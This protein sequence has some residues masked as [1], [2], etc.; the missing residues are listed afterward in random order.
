LGT[1]R[2]AGAAFARRAVVGGAAT[3]LLALAGR[4]TGWAA[5]VPAQEPGTA[6]LL[7]DAGRLAERL[8]DPGLRVLDVRARDKYD[9]GHLPTAVHVLPLDLDAVDERQVSNL[10]PADEAAQLLGAL[11]VGDGHQVAVYDDS[12]TFWAARVF[13]A[14]DY[15]GHPA[16]A[17]LDGGWPRWAATGR[18]SS[19]EVPSLPAATFTATPDPAKLAGRDEVLAGIGAHGTAIVDSRPTDVWRAGHVPGAVSLPWSESVAGAEPEALLKAPAELQELF[20]GAGVTPDREVITYCGAGVW[21]AQS[22][23]VLRRLGYPRVRLYDGSWQEWVQ[24]PALPV[25]TAA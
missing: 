17:V 24:D 21:S 12:Q 23:F 5:A 20:A 9:A 16:V 8:G 11:G 1:T 15:L 19:V 22:Y 3:A 2:A 7:V 4:R 10:K 14:L 25:E 13:W 6:P 18:P